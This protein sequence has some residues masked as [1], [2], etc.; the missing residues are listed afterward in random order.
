MAKFDY[1]IVEKR[2][3][4]AAEITRQVTSRRTVVSKRQL[5]FETEAEAVEW[6]E[7][8]LVEFAKN[9]AVRNER[10]SEQRSEREEIIARKKEK[11][12][13]QKAAY[14]AAR[15]EEE[16]EYDFDEE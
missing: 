7:K 15:D 3:A 9:Q 11:A 4:W 2:N 12:A 16:D 8:E 1:R 5:G 10:K 14:E 13:A 6:A